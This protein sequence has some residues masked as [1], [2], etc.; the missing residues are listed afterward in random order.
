MPVL[1][2]SRSRTQS[3]GAEIVETGWS[4]LC[5]A[6]LGSRKSRDYLK[7]T[8]KL[9]HVRVNLGPLASLIL[10][11]YS[12]SQSSDYNAETFSDARGR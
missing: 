1:G 10:I 3:R 8:K 5:L 12:T 2:F 4:V 7:E 9:T 11:S 6:A